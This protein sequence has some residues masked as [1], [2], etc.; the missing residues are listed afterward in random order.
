[1]DNKKDKLRT[2]GLEN[3]EIANIAV[4]RR[5]NSDLEALK[6]LGGPFTSADAVDTYIQDVEIDMNDKINRLC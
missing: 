4:Y 1:M 3:K 6:A 2:Q 5:K